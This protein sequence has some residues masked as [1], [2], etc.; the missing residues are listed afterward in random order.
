MN[1][2]ETLSSI[3]NQDNSVFSAI[4]LFVD[5]IDIQTLIVAAYLARTQVYLA[6][7]CR[8]K[9]GDSTV[10]RK[11]YQPRMKLECDCGEKDCVH[12]YA[13]KIWG[14]ACQ[15]APSSNVAQAWMEKVIV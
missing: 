2:T 8:Y 15:I 14:I 7:C 10:C 9:V 6:G 13:V 4:G 1:V 12:I 11:W 3:R 5:S